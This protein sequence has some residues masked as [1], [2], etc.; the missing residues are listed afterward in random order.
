MKDL[1]GLA[2]MRECVAWALWILCLARIAD[3]QAGTSLATDDT[4]A[5][6]EIQLSVRLNK[7]VDVT[8]AGQIRASRNAGALVD[9]RTGAGFAMRPNH[10]LTISPF[11]LY[12]ATQPAGQAKGIENRLNLAFTVRMPD[13][14]GFTI[15]S[16][17]LF[18]RRIRNPKYSTRYRQRLQIEFPLSASGTEWRAFVSDELFYDSSFGEWVR[19]RFAV[20]VIRSF[21]ASLSC[22]VY[23]MR[24][25][26]G[27]T[28]P[29]NLHVMGVVLR[30]RV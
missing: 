25:N 12:I 26:D 1:R 21:S 13:I 24:Q 29:G 2:A 3:A 16:R 8:A 19:N 30:V 10:W 17:S 23:Y 5:W 4:Q 18:E 20:G 6:P 9:E 27:R 22:D 7:S 15:A 28:R 11:Y 14:K